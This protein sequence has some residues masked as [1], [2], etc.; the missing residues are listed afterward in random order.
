MAWSAPMTMTTGYILSAADWNR[1]VRDNF[2]ALQPV[3]ATVATAQSGASA[4]PADLGTVGP[5]ITLQTGSAV[6]VLVS[7]LMWNNTANGQSYAGV[8]VSGATTRAASSEEALRMSEA[9][10]GQA[11]QQG[12]TRAARITGLTPGTNTFT[13]KYWVSGGTG[14]FQSRELQV[15]AA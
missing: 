12:A 10:A 13:M 1:E 7:A 4:T 3:S 14:T 8:A 9:V 6:T 2:L 5:Q 15:I 11:G